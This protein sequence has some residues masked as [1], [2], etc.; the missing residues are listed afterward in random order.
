MKVEFMFWF[1]LGE[2]RFSALKIPKLEYRSLLND[3]HLN[4]LMTL[5]I[6]KYIHSYNELGE[7]IS[8]VTLH[9]IT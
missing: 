6:T 8:S 7:V 4:D 2:F 1:Y 9:K 3:E 5:A